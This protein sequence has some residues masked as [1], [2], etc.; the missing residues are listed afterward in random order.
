MPH[1][2]QMRRFVMKD[3]GERRDL[4]WAAANNG[5]EVRIAGFLV[6]G[7]GDEGRERAVEPPSVHAR[8]KMLCR[9]SE[10]KC[11]MVGAT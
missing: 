3:P 1:D 10:G 2:P 4:N 5:M 7:A 11:S 8:A 6:N 9:I